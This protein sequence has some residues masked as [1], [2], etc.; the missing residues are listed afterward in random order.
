MTMYDS[1]I[2]DHLKIF[3]D[4]EVKDFLAINKRRKNLRKIPK[5]L[6]IFLTTSD[7]LEKYAQSNSFNNCV[8][9]YDIY[10]VNLF[11]IELQPIKTKPLIKNKFSRFKK[12]KV[13]TMLPLD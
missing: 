10:I 6:Y 1:K 12:C 3:T 5:S 13:Q 9:Y 2:D 11:D 7:E 4:E 8:H